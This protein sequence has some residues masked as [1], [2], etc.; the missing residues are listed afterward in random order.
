VWSG[1]RWTKVISPHDRQRSAETQLELAKELNAATDG[2]AAVGR[3]LATSDRDL[4][5]PT[6]AA[7]SI[8]FSGVI[9]FCVTS[10][11]L[12]SVCFSSS[13]RCA[14]KTHTRMG[15]PVQEDHIAE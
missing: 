5:D 14:T 9:A 2:S 8:L 13:E 3:V 4:G 10:V 12:R 11:S 15:L 7:P 1:A 6:P